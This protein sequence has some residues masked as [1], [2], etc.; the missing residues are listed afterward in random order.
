LSK[1]RS[2]RRVAEVAAALE[3]GKSTVFHW[4]RQDRIDCGELA[5]TSM[6]ESA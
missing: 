2:G 3:L 6:A 1:V 5:G 4:V